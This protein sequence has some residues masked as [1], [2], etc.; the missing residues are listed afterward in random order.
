MAGELAQSVIDTTTWRWGI[1]MFAII[2]PVIGLLLC[3]SLISAEVRANRAGML[4]GIPSPFKALRSG[5]LWKDF[6]WQ[7]D[8]VGLLLIAAIF[9]FILVPLTLAGGDGNQWATANIIAPLVIGVV[10]CIPAFILWE[11]KFARHPVMP[12]RILKD[13][14]V[15]AALSVALLLNTA[16]YTQGDYLY[17]TLRVAFNQYVPSPLPMPRSRGSL[18]RPLR[19]RPAS[20][21]SSPSSL[22]VSRTIR[23]ATWIQNIYTFVSVVIGITVGIAVRYVRHLKYFAV[24]GT[25]L[26]VLA[27]G[28][29]YRYRGG[30]ETHELAGLIGAEVILGVAGGFFICPTTFPV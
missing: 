29:L 26:F 7:I 12:F 3:Y 20:Q 8:L 10:V 30:V 25:L 14:Q 28:L 23:H 27:F 5:H 9:A 22:G 6:F 19:S 24:A 18:C 13:R 4:A 17:Y 21:S 1:G 16:W 15:I 11:I 2:F